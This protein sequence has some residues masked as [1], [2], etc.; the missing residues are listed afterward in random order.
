VTPDEDVDTEAG[1]RGGSGGAPAD[2]ELAGGTTTGGVGWPGPAV[3][4]DA[5]LCSASGMSAGCVAICCRMPTHGTPPRV[6]SAVASGLNT[7]AVKNIPAL[8]IMTTTMPFLV[9][10]MRSQSFCV[11]PCEFRSLTGLTE[12]TISKIAAAT[13][14][15]L[16]NRCEGEAISS[17]LKSDELR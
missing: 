17:P 7:G 15:A 11:V 4:D 16:S 1:G 9:R 6:G 8:P 3:N 14:P 10:D 12:P 5:A 13:N 2:D